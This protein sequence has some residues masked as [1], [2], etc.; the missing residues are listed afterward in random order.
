LCKLH[1]Q[2]ADDGSIHSDLEGVAEAAAEAGASALIARTNHSPLAG[3]IIP[4]LCRVCSLFDALSILE[5]GPLPAC[6]PACGRR[7]RLLC[8]EELVEIRRNAP[9]DAPA[10][11]AL[12]D[13]EEGWR[14]ANVTC[15]RFACY[16]GRPTR[17]GHPR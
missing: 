13:E 1:G 15:P 16:L 17:D 4:P 5:Q 10:H 8:G 2:L 9:A 6:C 12:C 14:C 11:A 7:P 3:A